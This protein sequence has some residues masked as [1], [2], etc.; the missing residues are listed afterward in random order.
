MSRG[1]ATKLRGR[2]GQP[3]TRQRSH[4]EPDRRAATIDAPGM[5]FS[6]AWVR[7][8]HDG[9]LRAIRTVDLGLRHLSV[10]FVDHRGEPTRYPT[11][12]ELA[13]ARYAL[14]PDDIEVVM[15]LPPSEQFVALHDTCF[16][17]HELPDTEDRP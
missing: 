12:D 14:L 4:W 8:V 1:G 11:W 15:Y 7:R 17:L 16:H 2:P 10:S 3:L 9:E 13:D 5:K 6:G